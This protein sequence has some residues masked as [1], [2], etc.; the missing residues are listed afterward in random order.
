MFLLQRA[1]LQN[2]VATSGQRRDPA[3][4]PVRAQ[5]P[6]ATPLTLAIATGAAVTAAGFAGQRL[7]YRAAGAQALAGFV[8]AVVATL[9][10][11]T[12]SGMEFFP[13]R[14]A[15]V[16]WSFAWPTVIVLCLLVGPDRRAQTLIMCWY[17]GGLLL[18]CTIA[19]LAGTPGLTVGYV[20]VPG[21]FQPMLLWAINAVPSLFLLLFLN[22]TIRT[23]GPL[24]LVFVFIVLIGSHIALTIMTFEPVRD[25]VLTIAVASGFGGHAVF[26][27]VVSIGMLATAWPAWRGV[28]FLRDRYA[29]K[30][31]SEFMIT[32]GA[33]WLLQSLMLGISLSRE[34][35]ALGAA[36]AVVPLAA[37]RLTL[38]A[39]LRPMVAA[40][41]S[42]PASRLLLLRVFG[43]GRRSRRLLDL[44][45][46]RWRLV[47]SI[48][49]IAAPD[50]ASRTVEPAT[51][52]EFIRGHL[53]R[54]FIRSPDHQ[55]QRLLPSTGARIPTRAR[56]RVNQLFC[57]DDMWKDA[58]IRLMGSVPRGHGFTRLHPKPARLRLRIAN[59]A[60][61]RAY[62]PTAVLHRP[63]NR[64]ERP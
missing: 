63:D 33:I 30:R 59:A 21:F 44:L 7:M 5:R 18:L 12:M 37:W 4:E 46:S 2:M 50:L 3:E 40:A 11:L 61:Y 43:F 24:V 41:R 58:V 42:R 6:A 52:I 35:G 23:I 26:W 16:V 56:F 36:A 20:T 27:S 64:P 19:Q 38:F 39:G 10:L 14:V 60:R 47:G 25:S 8:F 9:L 29:A 34:Q 49:L 28:A 51:F 53:A 17:L 55:H 54:L 22:R 45:G 57:S 31:S 1:I 13:I 32:V 15:V 48:D 62:R